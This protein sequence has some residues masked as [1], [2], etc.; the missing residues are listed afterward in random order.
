[1]FIIKLYV[2]R[3][4]TPFIII[5]LRTTVS[6]ICIISKHV[7]FCNKHISKSASCWNLY[8]IMQQQ[9]VVTDQ[10]T[11]LQETWKTRQ[12][13]NRHTVKHVVFL[14]KYEAYVNSNFRYKIYLAMNDVTSM[15]YVSL[16]RQFETL[17]FYAVTSRIEALVLSRPKFLNACV[18][19]VYRLLL[20]PIAYCRFHLCI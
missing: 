9:S 5:S 18:E 1:M 2:F 3:T 10:Y 4:D 15:L 7:E 13:L 16:V 8:T 19:K 11:V 6:M 20:Q 12:I 14:R 17:L